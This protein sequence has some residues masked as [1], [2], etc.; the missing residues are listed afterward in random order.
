L[1]VFVADEPPPRPPPPPQ[2]PASTEGAITPRT[3][4]AAD[5][6]IIRRGQIARER[7]FMTKSWGQDVRKSI[8]ESNS[9]GASHCAKLNDTG[10]EELKRLRKVAAP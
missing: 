7:F 10:E 5:N 2:P 6:A 4:T 1:N 8:R 9:G 3:Q